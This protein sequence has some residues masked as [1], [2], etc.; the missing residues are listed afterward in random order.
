MK[1]VHRRSI[2]VTIYSEG[3]DAITVVGRLVDRR[4]SDLVT[5][6]GK[7]VAAGDELHGME[8]ELKIGRDLAVKSA[9]ARMPFVPESGCERAAP[10]VKALEG[11][12]LGKG[13][14]RAARE[15]VGGSAGCQHLTALVMAMAPAAMQGY[16]AHFG[17]P[18]KTGNL[19]PLLDTCHVFRSDSLFVERIKAAMKKRSEPPPSPGSGPVVA[20]ATERS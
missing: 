19:E 5:F 1:M 10:K 6:S 12:K 9:A 8:V 2:D 7:E 20:R 13:F 17:S 14:A 11:L 4:G 18:I 16:W 3:A 15:R